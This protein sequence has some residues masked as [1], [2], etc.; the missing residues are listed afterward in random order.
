MRQC[1]YP[2]HPKLLGDHI[3]KS[4][5]DQKL[6]LRDLAKMINNVREGKTSQSYLWEIEENLVNPSILFL[7]KVE[8]ALELKRGALTKKRICSECGRSEGK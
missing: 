4:R 2:N 6:S 5:M 1:K 7:K 3:R 8:E